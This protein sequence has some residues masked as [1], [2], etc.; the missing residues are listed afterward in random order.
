MRS[1]FHLAL[2]R[3]ECDSLYQTDHH[4]PLLNI[5]P[6]LGEHCG[7]HRRSCTM[8]N[9]SL[10]HSYWLRINPNYMIVDVKSP[11]GHKLSNLS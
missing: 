6:S 1:I 4:F 3:V 10:V 9:P 5:F 8:I 2:C 7:C 11:A